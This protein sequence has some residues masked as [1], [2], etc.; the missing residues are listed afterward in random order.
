MTWPAP[1]PKTEQWAAWRKAD[2]LAASRKLPGFHAGP[3][4]SRPRPSVSPVAQKYRRVIQHQSNGLAHYAPLLKHLKR[5]YPM[6]VA[7]IERD[8]K[9]LDKKKAR[10]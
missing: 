9:W 4:P 6:R 10:L 3:P 2:V 8:L 1:D 7:R 5:R